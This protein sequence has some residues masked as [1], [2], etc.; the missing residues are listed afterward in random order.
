MKIAVIGSGGREHALAWKFAKSV[1]WDN[2][3]TL[4]GNGGIPNSFTINIMDFDAIKAF[5]VQQKIDL[6]FVGPKQPLAAGMVDY[7]RKTNIQIFGPTQKVAQLEASKVYAKYF[8]QKY[9]VSTARFKIFQNTTHAK[10][11][12]TQMHGFCVIKYD[13]L[14]AGKGV[15]LCGNLSELA[16]AFDVIVATYGENLLLVV[17][18]RLEG[19]EISIIG[20]TDGKTVKLL[21]ASQNYKQL[22]EG[23]KGV[24]TS[25]MGA[26]SPIEGLDPVLMKKIHL[27][28]IKPTMQGIE[29]E[30][31]DYKGM[32]NFG[33]MVENGIPYLLEYNTRFGDTETEVI[34]PALKTDL[35]T[36]VA[37]CFN[38]NISNLEFETGFFS[39]VV[40]V[41]RG[42]PKEYAKGLSIYGLE[43]LEKDILIFHAGTKKKE[44]TLVTHGGRVLH[45]VGHGATLEES[46]Q[47]VYNQIQKIHFD[48]MYF[49]KDIGKRRNG[50]FG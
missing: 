5:C 14:A 30:K 25:G 2:V 28:I 31:M 18:Q 17:E 4:P 19:D 3:F 46:L 13:G 41:S 42:Y 44:A 47:K 40:L 50:N 35:V 34:L 38:G 37:A 12:A 48:G 15:F 11:Y 43:N 45:V 36:I 26:H 16:L 24:N 27:R 49:R 29:E 23:D 32:I 9:E 1:G 6:I 8:M 39:D 7:F 10:E 21:Q 22:L 20:F 33:I